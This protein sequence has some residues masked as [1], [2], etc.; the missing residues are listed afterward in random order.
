MEGKD[1]ELYCKDVGMDCDFLACGKTEEEALSNLGHHV[2]ATHGIK[3]F[4]KEFYNKARSA[5]REGY[6]GYGDSE[7]VISEDYSESYESCLDCADER[8]C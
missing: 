6:C 2:L 7:E 5:I 1:K 4:S 8:C 3:G